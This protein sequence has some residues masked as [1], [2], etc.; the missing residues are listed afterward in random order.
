LKATG[1]FHSKRNRSKSQPDIKEKD[2]GFGQGSPLTQT[3]AYE[4]S[5]DMNPKLML[6]KSRVGPVR[7]RLHEVRRA[8]KCE[9]RVKTD[10]AS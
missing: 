1:K 5:E 6:S 3:S 2:P 8:W 4:R 7:A 9:I 10:T